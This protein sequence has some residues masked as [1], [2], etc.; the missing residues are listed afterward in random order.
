MTADRFQQ[1]LRVINDFEQE[2]LAYRRGTCPSCKQRSVSAEDLDGRIE[3]ICSVCSPDEFQ[4]AVRRALAGLNGAG[5]GEAK[6]LRFPLIDFAQLRSLP[7]PREQVEDFFLEQSVVQG[8]GETNHGKSLLFWDL[9]LNICR[10]SETWFGRRI[11]LHG[12]VVW[13][14][15]DGG[16]GLTLRAN[17]W[18]EAHGDDL[19]HPLLTLMGSVR[20]N[21]RRE[22]GEFRRQL[23]SMEERPVLVVFDTQSRCMPGGDEN[24][25]GVMTQV[26]EGIHRL[27]MEVGCSVVLI[28]HTDK[29]GQW[30]RGSGVVKNESDHQIRI[31]KDEDSGIFTVSCRKARDAD[32]FK[33]FY[34]KLQQVGESVVIVQHGEPP[35]VSREEAKE[36]KLGLLEAFLAEWPGA[37]ATYIMRE[38]EM[39]RST[40]YRHVD[41]LKACVPQRIFT[42]PP[43]DYGNEEWTTKKPAGY[44]PVPPG[45]R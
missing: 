28:H 22:I 34:F 23:A 25:Q 24:D 39:T 9:A 6:S 7:P 10:G 33:D 43:V 3:V 37:T 18:A 29:T 31:T 32:P 20:L 17:A 19:K 15:A 35:P 5:H 42:G 38:L 27:K 4:E 41:E 36:S 12:P 26:T 8:F 13:I 2:G 11:L 21:D 30:E 40:F 45:H 44:Y 14:N 16:R 1:V